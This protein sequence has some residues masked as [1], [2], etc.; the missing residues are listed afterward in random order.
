MSDKDIPA[1][2]KNPSRETC[3]K[4]IR[5]ILMA[6]ILERG[7]NDHFRS[8]SDFMTYFE[9]LYPASEAL[10]KQVQRAIKSLAMPK[11]ESGYFI[12]NKTVEQLKQE[13]ELQ[14]LFKKAH[15]QVC[16]MEKCVPVFLKTEP[17]LR[18]YVMHVIENS[19]VFQNKFLTLQETS[20]G[21]ILYTDNPSQLM[22]LLNSIIV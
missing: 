13:Q 9:S 10:T 18:F 14:I 8:A 21:I 15:A 5:K 16:P 17:E 3:E 19:P 6:E 20:N 11:D 12:P 22:F 1:L 7:K 2:R 4:I